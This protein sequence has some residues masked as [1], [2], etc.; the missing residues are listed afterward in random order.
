MHTKQIPQWIH[1]HVFDSGN[2]VAERSTRVVMWITAATMLIEV[3]AGW[4]FNSMALLADGWH[5]SSHALAIGL[6]A[7][8]YAAARRYAHDPRFAF[9]TWKIEILGGFASAIFLLGVA[10]MMVAG[11]VER[12]FS[13]T[14]IQYREAIVVAMLGLAVNVICAL[15]LGKAHYHVH[16]HEHHH[17]HHHHDLN[18]KSAYVHVIADAATSMLAI[19]ALVG[20]WLYGWS[21]LDP[22]MGIIGAVLV[23]IWAKGLIVETGKVLLDREMDH[24]VVNEI[25]EVVEINSGL[26]ASHIVDLHVW[27]VGQQSYSCALTVV[28][29]DFSMTPG[30]VRDR[31]AVHEEIVHS[32]IEVH[33]HQKI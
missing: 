15:I 29:Q 14:P 24:P 5:M 2:V 6:S 20:G 10:G 27:R 30:V 3:G 28:T 22:L 7:M 9:G 12:M 8:A 11:S 1:D 18:L 23:A 33:Y 32:T 4:W 31:L 17:G 21:W 25:R 26:G 19:A 13:P 16:G